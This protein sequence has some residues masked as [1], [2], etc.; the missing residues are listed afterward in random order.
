[1]IDIKKILSLPPAERDDEI[2]KLIVPK[3]WK[4][5]WEFVEI[6]KFYDSMVEADKR[7]QERQ[8]CKKCGIS[9]TVEIFREFRGKT[10][11]SIYRVTDPCPILDRI[12]LDW[13]LAMKMRDECQHMK[14]WQAM[15][16]VFA[17]V[18]AWGKY[19]CG[20]NVDMWITTK[21][22]PH[23]YIL[24]ACVAKEKE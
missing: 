3:P 8:I 19:N 15:G 14:F 16:E 23:H 10:K 12:S 20:L 24:A 21:A 2:R 18:V 9:S 4:H 1:M 11:E 5:D 22:Q 7:Q 13:N 6:L 17:I